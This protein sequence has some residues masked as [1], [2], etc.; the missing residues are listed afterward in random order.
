VEDE[1]ARVKE[2]LANTQKELEEERLRF[3]EAN[4]LA[5]TRLEE[6]ETARESITQLEPELQEAN[7]LAE[8]R[9]EDLE[10]AQE[11]ITQLESELEEAIAKDSDDDSAS[12]NAKEM[13]LQNKL[14]EQ[15][16]LSR[17]REREFKK[18]TSEL[19]QKSD[20]VSHESQPQ[21][22]DLVASSA[23]FDAL[24]AEL[25]S[26]KE[27][28]AMSEQVPSNNASKWREAELKNEIDALKKEVKRAKID[29]MSN[30]SNADS[31]T[32][33]TSISS[34]V[35]ANELREENERLRVELKHSQR[36]P[37]PPPSESMTMANYKSEKK[38]KREIAKLKEANTKILDTAEQQFSSLLDLEKENTELRSVIEGLQDGDNMGGLDSSFKDSLEKAQARMLAEKARAEEAVAREAKL[39]TEIAQMRLNQQQ[40]NGR[41]SR[42]TMS[43][44][45]I[46]DHEATNEIAT[47][48][49]EIERLS[50]ELL[51]AK[52]EARNTDTFSADDMMRKYD[53]LK[54]LAES[55]M[56]KDLEIEKLKMRVNTQDAE[57][58]SLREEVTEEDLTF[59][60]RE[61]ADCEDDIAAAQNTGLRSLNDE[62]S[63]QLELYKKDSDD[64]KTRLSEERTRS[65]MEMKAF[66]VALKGVDDLRIAAENM[67][68][69]LHF[70]K[71]HGYVPSGGLT[72]TDASGHVQSAMSAVESMAVASQSIDHPALNDQSSVSQ[73]ERGRDGFNLWNAM[74]AVMGPGQVQAM[75]NV[76]ESTGGLFNGNPSVS[77]KSS[78]KHKS[79]RRKKKGSGGSVISSFF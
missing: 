54:R 52:E 57:L 28:L 23:K 72:G 40:K 21:S 3:Q 65:E 47:L 60:V 42:T 5:E 16:S 26:T 79:G 75:Q 10:T 76:S 12:M 69:E 27:K 66:S 78:S 7:D 14:D 2:E 30:K 38:M 20:S 35:E 68:R 9:R 41:S 67:S 46:S 61:Y 1:L 37:S 29:C 18:L 59:G 77:K 39:R 24:K 63:K 62:L 6:L 48:Q 71:K 32:E 15:I 58:N 49:Y 53:E 56:Q 50:T 43:Q 73:R 44:Q 31:S 33:Y 36:A 74:N 51:V 45:H 13:M 64:A 25:E 70:I 17:Q 55:G 22:A 8:T 19:S 4:D 11:S 34:E